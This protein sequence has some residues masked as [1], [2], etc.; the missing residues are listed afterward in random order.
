MRGSKIEKS[1]RELSLV[2]KNFLGVRFDPI[3]G[4]CLLGGPSLVRYRGFCQNLGCSFPCRGAGGCRIND[5]LQYF[6]GIR[7]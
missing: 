5:Q 6:E 4:R 2:E 3:P 7:H 1:T